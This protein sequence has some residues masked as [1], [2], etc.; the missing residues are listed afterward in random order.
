MNQSRKI[1]IEIWNTKIIHKKDYELN[2]DIFEEKIK[3]YA[4]QQS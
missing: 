2:I 4:R 1:A 3:E